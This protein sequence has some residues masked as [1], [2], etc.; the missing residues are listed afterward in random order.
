MAVHRLSKLCAVMGGP[1]PMYIQAALIGLT[2][3]SKSEYESMEKSNGGLQGKRE[4]GRIWV[5]YSQDTLYTY[6]ICQK[7]NQNNILKESILT[8]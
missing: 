8:V 7:I 2:G 5:R 1:I 4:R 6:G 3:L